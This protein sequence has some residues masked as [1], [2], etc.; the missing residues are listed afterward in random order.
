MFASDWKEELVSEV[1]TKDSVR[2]KFDDVIYITQ[3]CR[4][5]CKSLWEVV[6]RR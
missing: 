4:I 1:C 5:H 6:Y 2:Y 3:P